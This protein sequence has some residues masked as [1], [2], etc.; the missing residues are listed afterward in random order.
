LKKDISRAK[1]ISKWVCRISVLAVFIAINFPAASG[2]EGSSENKIILER[3]SALR[4]DLHSIRADVSQE[5]QLAILRKK[6]YVSGAVTIAKPNRLRWEVSKPDRS[7]TVID[8]E[9][10]TVYHPDLKEA[11]T[12]KLSENIMA[13]NS[14][15]LFAS[16]MSGAIEELEKKF[17]VEVSSWEN[18][19]VLRLVPISRI[20]GR[21][22]SS[23]TIY[24]DKAKGLPRA[25][26]VL[27]PKGDSTLT[28]L[29]NITIN[30]PIDAETFRMKLPP[31][32]WITNKF[33][34]EQ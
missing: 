10:M 22:L 4:K 5:K 3:L 14:L 19:I 16:A 13:R 29:E 15:S 17:K 11:Q 21:Y 26:E 28:K 30:P 2:S 33:D 31:D 25:F 6:V 32:A 8:G 9:T 20:A 24:Y 18:E 27:T 34:A 23:V 7:V 12:Y 1:E